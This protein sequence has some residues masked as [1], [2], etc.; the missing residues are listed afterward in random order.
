MSWSQSSPLSSIRFVVPFVSGAAFA[1]GAVP[2]GVQEFATGNTNR[3]ASANLA[4]CQ[5]A[6]LIVG[7]GV[8]GTAGC[9]ARVQYSTDGGTVWDYLDAVSGPLTSIAAITATIVPGAWAPIV[10]AARRDVLLRLVTI[11]GNAVASPTFVH[12]LLELS[13]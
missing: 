2:A 3:R 6:R 5:W 13:S 9:E 11:N 12:V 7:G 1:A 10:A 4:G 8:N